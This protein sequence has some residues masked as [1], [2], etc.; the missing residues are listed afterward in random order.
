MKRT[1][2]YIDW[3]TWRRAKAAATR[4]GQTVSNLIRTMLSTSLPVKEK[5]GSLENLAT[6]GK[7]FAWPKNTPRDLSTNLDHYLYGTPKKRIRKKRV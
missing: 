1:Q 7:T 2:L 4:R 3:E 5:G 6:L